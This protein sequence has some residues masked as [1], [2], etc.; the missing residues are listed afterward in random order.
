MAGKRLLG[1]LRLGII[2]ILFMLTW[3]SML[4][5]GIPLALPR[6]AQ[7]IPS[8]SLMY[9]LGPI[10]RVSIVRTQVLSI[11][12]LALITRFR[13]MVEVQLVVPILLKTL[14]VWT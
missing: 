14:S 4:C 1:S 9:M 2:A 6:G 7:T 10:R 12:V 11:L 8:L 5:I 3:V 13:A